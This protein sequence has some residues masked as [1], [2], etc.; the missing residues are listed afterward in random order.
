MYF[1]FSMMQYNGNPQISSFVDKKGIASKQPYSLWN[2]DIEEVLGNLGDDADLNKLK[3]ETRVSLI[4]DKGGKEIDKNSLKKAMK[5][6][7]N[8]EDPNIIESMFDNLP[9]PNKNIINN[10]SGVL[11]DGDEGISEPSMI[12]NKPKKKGRTKKAANFEDDDFEG[13]SIMVFW[14]LAV[15]QKRIIKNDYIDNLNPSKLTHGAIIEDVPPPQYIPTLQKTYS[16]QEFMGNNRGY[17][18]YQ[19]LPL[20]NGV[21]GSGVLGSNS[22][23]S[24]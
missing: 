16:D 15:P 19:S 7:Q 3:D 20:T 4:P 23:L 9:D 22:N 13:K 24:S 6:F 21:L 5:M 11:D 18:D 8:K 12:E 10:Y 14:S 17:P 1:I 2:L